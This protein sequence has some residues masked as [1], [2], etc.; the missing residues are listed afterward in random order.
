[1]LGVTGKST[2]HNAY[3]TEQ[4]V[5]NAVTKKDEKVMR[6]KLGKYW[7]DKTPKLTPVAQ[8]NASGSLTGGKQ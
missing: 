8:P 7:E 2:V 4:G 6:N 3:Y 5:R 1:M